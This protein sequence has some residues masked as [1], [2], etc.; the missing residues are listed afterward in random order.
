M[1]ITLHKVDPE[2][3][4]ERCYIYYIYHKDAYARTGKDYCHSL[5]MS[6]KLKY[7]KMVLL[8][9]TGNLTVESL[10]TIVHGGWLYN[11]CGICELESSE[12]MIVID[13]GQEHDITICKSCSSVVT[14]LAEEI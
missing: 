6:Y 7:D 8:K 4:M 5:E 12:A 11:F 1:S 13:G 10:A 3:I 14:K 2:S 9:E